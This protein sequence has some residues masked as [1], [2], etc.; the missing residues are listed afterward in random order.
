MHPLSLRSACALMLARIIPVAAICGQQSPVAA[1]H[2]DTTIAYIAS[3]TP[4]QRLDLFLP[5]PKHAGFATVVFTYGGGW[6]APRG[7]NVGLVCE[8]FRA[9][10]LA[11][12]L[13][14][15]RLAPANPFPAAEADEA[16]AAAW[17]LDNIAQFG[18]D[19]RRVA[20]VGHSSGAHLAVLV[21]TDPKWLARSNHRP[22]DLAAVVGLSTPTDLSPRADGRGYGDALL[23][24]AGA[25][26]FGRDTTVMRDAS[27]IQHA[28]QSGPPILL[29]VGSADFP[30][31]ERDATAFAAARRGVEVMIAMGR[32]HMGTVGALVEPANPVVNRVMAFLQT[33][34]HGGNPP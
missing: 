24:G 28:A 23:G 13:V 5:R 1:I 19:P 9:R 22:S 8:A 3:G 11:C 20:L 32:D 25:A 14:A 6:H 7:P 17:I 26:A 21:A 34:S 29:V 30:M 15:H 16:A 18:G 31:L 10:G 27:P 12:A 2:A 4:E 33:H